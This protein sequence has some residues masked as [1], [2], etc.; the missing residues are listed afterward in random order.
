[1]HKFIKRLKYVLW[2]LAHAQEYKSPCHYTYFTNPQH[3]R[4]KAKELGETVEC[5]YWRWT[6]DNP[7]VYPFRVFEGK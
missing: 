4:L 6:M 2:C 7:T 5:G 3:A 1:M